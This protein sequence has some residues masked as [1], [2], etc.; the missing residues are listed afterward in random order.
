MQPSAPEIDRLPVS[1]MPQV[2]VREAAFSDYAAVAGLMQQY[3]MEISAADEWEQLWKG[4]PVYRQRGGN[5]PIGWALENGDRNIVGFSGNIPV[6]CELGGVTLTAAVTTGWVVASDYRSRSMLLASKYFAQK[7]VDLLL[8]TTASFEAGQI[9][10]AFHAKPIPVEDLDSAL[11]WVIDHRKFARST[12]LRK[13][14]PL[15]TVLSYPLGAASAIIAWAKG[16]G[17]LKGPHPTVKTAERFDERFDVFWQQLREGAQ[18]ITSV[19][20]RSTLEWHF[21]RSL[22][23]N[24]L[25]I[26]T[27]ERDGKLT[28]Y[29]LFQREDKP[30]LGLTRVRMVDFQSLDEN[31]LI[32]DAMVAAALSQCKAVGAQMLEVVGFA[33]QIRSRLARLAPFR[34]KLPSWLFYYKAVS[35]ELKVKLQDA[36]LWQPCGYD[37]DSSL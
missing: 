17:R 35:K 28:S 32:L 34:R 12:L 2:S 13:H 26:Y 29:A 24:D 14:V 37:G 31:P 16:S 27:C 30:E 5:W 19:R 20:D 9:F 6:A 22:K 23:S 18:A 1:S 3:G 15:A 4:N 33:G 11:F 25:W 10:R 7:D 8:N 21:S 36:Q